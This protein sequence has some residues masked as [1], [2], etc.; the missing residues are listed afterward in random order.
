MTRS[1]A[2]TRTPRTTCSRARPADPDHACK[3]KTDRSIR[4]PRLGDRGCSGTQH[5]RCCCGHL[6]PKSP[7][8]VRKRSGARTHPT[9]MERRRS[10]LAGEGWAPNGLT[11]LQ[12]RAKDSGTNGSRGQT[13]PDGKTLERLAVFPW[14]A[15]Q[16][17]REATACWRYLLPTLRESCGGVRGRDGG[18]YHKWWDGSVWRP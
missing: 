2:H 9:H 12:L 8:C 14:R 6:G 15:L 1:T 3:H 13:G 17:V 7:R 11:S 16:L 4:P 18:L 10:F 5:Q